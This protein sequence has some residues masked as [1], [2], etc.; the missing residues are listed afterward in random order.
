MFEDRGLMTWQDTLGL[1][2]HEHATVERFRGTHMTADLTEQVAKTERI[3]S[4]VHD[5]Y[6]VINVLYRLTQNRHRSSLDAQECVV[7]WFSVGFTEIVIAR[8]LQTY[9]KICDFYA[10]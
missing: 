4:S 5:N 7:V 3:D 1:I 6:V 9:I 8:L 10:R 2:F